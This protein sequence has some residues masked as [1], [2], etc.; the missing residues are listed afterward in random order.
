MDDKKIEN[1]NTPIVE[2][3]K[4]NVFKRILKSLG[5][6][7]SQIG[8]DIKRAVSENP[9]WIFGLLLMVPAVLI[10][11][12]LSSHIKASFA[13]P[14]SAKYTG[15]EMFVLE[16]AGCLNVVWGFSIIKKR[17]L[18]S[19]IF[20]VIT[21]TIIVVCGIL[22]VIE[23]FKAPDIS[24]QDGTI[25][26]IFEYDSACIVSVI[27]TLISLLCAVVGTVGSFFFRNK[28]YKKDTL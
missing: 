3:K 23:F 21:T 25:Q 16:M 6:Y 22:W 1:G 7:F 8:Y 12:L 5:K 28:N 18:K 11:F 27:T 2:N 20:A 26:S 24:F 13:L 17:N 4:D 10:G 19:S 14:T 9:N 15:F